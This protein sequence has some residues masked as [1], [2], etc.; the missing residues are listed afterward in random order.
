MT[1]RRPLQPLAPLSDHTNT[2][3]THITTAQ[4]DAAMEEQED[5]Q[6][7]SSQDA[8]DDF[9]RRM[10]QNA[11][12]ERR[13]KEAL[14][15]SS[16]VHAFRKART[17]PRVGLTL[18]NLE[19][20]NARNHAVT[21]T[22]A[23]VKFQSPPSSSGSA[24]SDPAIHAPAGWGRKSRSNRNWMRTITYDEQAQTPPPADE[25]VNGLY[26]D[27]MDDDRAR[28]SIED[29]PLSHKSTPR[30]DRSA[31]WDLTFELN[32]AS[33][34][35]STPYIPRNTMLDDI[36]QREA[37]SLK[38]ETVPESP[39]ESTRRPQLP[40]PSK[41]ADIA[42]PPAQGSSSPGKRLRTITNSWQAIG[43]SQPVTGTGKETSPV[44]VYKTST[45]TVSVWEQ[46]AV[47]GTRSRPSRPLRHR[48]ED[49]QDLLRRLARASN[50]PSPGRSEASRPQ[51]APASQL[52]SASQPIATESR[53]AS[54]HIEQH[55]YKQE[56]EP[57]T[58]T[59]PVSAAH[60]QEQEEEAKDT[61]KEPMAP[62]VPVP[63]RKVED[64]DVTPMPTE[65]RPL[66]AKTPVVTGAWVD[67]PGPRTI[68]KHISIARSPS[69][70][71]KKSSPQKNRSPQKS[72][73]SAVEEVVEAPV[74]EAVRPQLPRSALQALVQEAK[75][76]GR[77]E[78]ADFGDST[79]NSLEDLISSPPEGELDEDTL[80]GLQ[81]P[82]ITPRND[83][84][85]QR[86]Q[87]LLHLH[88]MN[89]RLR[90][91]RTSIRDASRGMKRV[92]DRVEHSE[93]LTDGEK[94]ILS[95]PCAASGHHSS[96]LQKLKQL[97]W[98]PALKS[99][100][101]GTSWRTLGG[102]TTLS[103]LLLILFTWWVSEE[104][105]CEMYCQHPYANFSPYR[106]SV[107]ENAPRF[108]FVIPTLV[109]RNLF[110]W[111]PS[112]VWSGYEAAAA[113]QQGARS[114]AAAWEARSHVAE[115][116]VWD[117]SMLRDEVIR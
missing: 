51:T 90:A 25:T 87:E 46:E 98:N 66:E 42:E 91:A 43:K 31:E 92:E 104:I 44:A 78:S 29:S 40:P 5:I 21:E 41:D 82:T 49:S 33:I 57:E 6:D 100:R 114:T 39:S 88:R 13:L 69:Q 18:D 110:W 103:I 77:R 105:A 37:E 101:A 10:I 107:N 36:R 38:V 68:R 74:P 27:H 15:S 3:H 63:G 64:V 9:E 112:P 53:P 32:E 81:L 65:R 24:R 7:L 111:M 35:A 106:F 30:H 96:L 71:P 62:S 28:P 20:N 84:E 70:S 102:L 47:S 99:K 2:R 34:I 94:S 1:T 4:S 19:R 89:D 22:N 80:L 23:H 113:L 54:A 59:E 72:K 76:H 97:F 14:H 115:E 55:T 109:S 16:R 17:Q 48:R 93:E 67:T 61:S 75:A 116:V 8:D 12:D 45:E 117:Q 86:Q 52:S 56:P 95:C 26:D 60:Q 11:R 85:R 79:I 58:P 108:P 73:A 83:A 50:T